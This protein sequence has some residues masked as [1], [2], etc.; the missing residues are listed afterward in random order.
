M[1]TTERVVDKIQTGVKEALESL[2]EEE[3]RAAVQQAKERLDKRVP[4]IV[5]GVAIQL[6]RLISIH[7]YGQ[8][9]R[10]AV[11]LDTKV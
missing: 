10:V 11:Q 1:L 4:E 6:H 3:V 8:E 5:A 2:I 7:T 9:I